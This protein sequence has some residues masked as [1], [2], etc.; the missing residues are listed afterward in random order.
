MLKCQTSRFKKKTAA[1]KRHQLTQRCYCIRNDISN[2]DADGVPFASP[3]GLW[4]GTRREIAFELEISAPIGLK[5]REFFRCNIEVNIAEVN[6]VKIGFNIRQQG[7][8]VINFQYKDVLIGNKGI[9]TRR[10][11]LWID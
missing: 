11:T 6:L 7:G 2:K 1:Q 4:R 9:P 10:I 5:H 3:S 8:H